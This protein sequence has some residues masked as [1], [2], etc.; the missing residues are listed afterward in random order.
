MGL[1][2]DIVNHRRQKFIRVTSSSSLSTSH[3]QFDIHFN[4]DTT[5]QI[6]RSFC[7]TAIHN[8]SFI[9]PGTENLPK[10]EANLKEEI[11]KPSELKHVEVAEKIVLPSAEDLKN[12]KVHENLQ[13]G[14]EGFTPDKLKAVKTKEPA[15][16][17]DLMKTEIATGATIKAV[18]GF[19]AAALKKAETVEKNS[20]PDQEAIKAEKEHEQFKSGIEGFDKDKLKDV[21][22]M[23]KNTLPTKE[24]IE[25]EKTA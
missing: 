22:T 14:I 20:L 15:S 12:E 9:M 17:A 8:K 23:E 25:Q 7:N 5:S 21:Q 19:D 2:Q 24:T 10:V 4:S 18:E 16:G 11:E 13:K 6:P 3:S 1:D